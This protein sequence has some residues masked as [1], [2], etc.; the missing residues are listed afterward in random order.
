MSNL[1]SD[2]YYEILGVSK[3]VNEVELKKAYKKLVLKWHPDKNKQTKISEENFKK[4]TSAYD[5]LSDKKKKKN[6]R[7]IWLM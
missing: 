6:L 1:K 2:N 4:I 5:V 7:Y 3:K